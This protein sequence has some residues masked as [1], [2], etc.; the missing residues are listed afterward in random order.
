VI[1]FKSL[2]S[3]MSS[4]LSLILTINTEYKL[5]LVLNY[6]VEIF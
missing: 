5:G 2:V 1:L 3:C 6:Y 4:V